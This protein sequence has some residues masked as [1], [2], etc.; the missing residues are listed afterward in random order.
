MKPGSP[1]LKTVVIEDDKQACEALVMM[2]SARKDIMMAGT[3]GS[4]EDGI[5]LLEKAKP[6]LA[7][8]DIELTDGTAFDL[9][10]R[11]RTHTT[12]P[13]IV[14]TTVHDRYAIRAFKY[15]AFD[16]LLKPVEAGE[17]AACL[18]R[19][20]ESSQHESR[21]EQVESLL[22]Q[23][24]P[25]GQ[26]RFNV[27]NGFILVNPDDILYVMADSNYSEIFFTPDHCEIVTTHLGRMEEILPPG[28]FFRISRSVLVNLRFL[29]RVNTL[30]CSCTLLK[31]GK[32]VTLPCSL[33]QIV[34]LKKI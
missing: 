10:D 31:D 8:L 32:S 17:L 9:L 30:S 22:Q 7:F 6:D 34:N 16:Y 5:R 2:I 26:I 21:R 23:I 19:V 3:A 29:K 13:R 33:K 4:V 24:K 25:A 27:R 11:T 12:L 14:F 15:A 18:D 28:R 20:Q 1:K